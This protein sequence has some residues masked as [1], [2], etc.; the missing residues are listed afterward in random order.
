[1]NATNK[2]KNVSTKDFGDKDT[3]NP[4]NSP[5]LDNKREQIEKFITS[6]DG[7]EEEHMLEESVCK[8]LMFLK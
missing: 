3:T 7:Q 6:Y 4:N 8:E 1:M 5:Y 2:I